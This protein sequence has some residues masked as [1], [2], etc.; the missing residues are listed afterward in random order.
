MNVTKIK[1]YLQLSMTKG[2]CWVSIG[3]RR[4]FMS[5]CAVSV[6]LVK[7]NNSIIKGLFPRP[8]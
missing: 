8:S 5:H 2:Q 4:K 7:K 3:Y 6:T 1:K